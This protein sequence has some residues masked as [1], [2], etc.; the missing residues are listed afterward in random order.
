VLDVARGDIPFTADSLPAVW[1]RSDKVERAREAVA[2]YERRK[3]PGAE[4]GAAV[5]GWVCPGCGEEIEAQFS[6]CWNCQ[7]MREGEKN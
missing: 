3:R 4:P 1:V 6:Q 7:M 2:E 5:G